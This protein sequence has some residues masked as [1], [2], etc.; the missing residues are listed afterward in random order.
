MEIPR[1]TDSNEVNGTGI[2]ARVRA[3]HFGNDAFA[4]VV[5]PRVAQTMAKRLGS[6]QDG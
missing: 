6:K 3:Q 2:T 5:A 4:R 1:D